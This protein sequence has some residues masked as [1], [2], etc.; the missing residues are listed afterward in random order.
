MIMNPERKIAV[1]FI[2]SGF[3][4]LLLIAFFPPIIVSLKAIEAVLL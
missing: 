1:R 2:L 4:C 3:F